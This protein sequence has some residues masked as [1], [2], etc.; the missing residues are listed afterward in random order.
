MARVRREYVMLGVLGGVAGLV[1]LFRDRI[2]RAVYPVKI[3]VDKTDVKPGEIITIYADA[4]PVEDVD[5]HAYCNGTRVA[6]FT[7][8]LKTLGYNSS[9]FIPSMLCT[10]NVLTLIGYGRDSARKSNTVTIRITR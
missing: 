5:I 4:K 10:G 8:Y 2:L 1:Y 3:W 7:I 9:S 6:I